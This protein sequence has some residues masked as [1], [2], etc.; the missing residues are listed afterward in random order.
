M[1]KHICGKGVDQNVPDRASGIVGKIWVW[2]CVARGG[3]L[4]RH[5]KETAKINQESFQSHSTLISE[6]KNKKIIPAKH[7][8]SCFNRSPVR[9]VRTDRP[10]GRSVRTVRADGPCGRFVRT[11]RTDRPYG[12]SLRTV[13]FFVCFCQEGSTVVFWV[14]FCFGG[15]GLWFVLRARHCSVLIC[16]T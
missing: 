6:T 10:Y 11:V 5:E 2:G 15:S 4:C 8:N 13:L 14:L 3:H 9:T 16:K 1:L 12:P 7:P